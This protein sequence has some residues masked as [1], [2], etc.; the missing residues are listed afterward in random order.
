MVVK[1]SIG[2]YLTG[3][4][5]YVP[6]AYMAY[7]RRDFRR[8]SGRG[9]RAEFCYNVFLRHL[10]HVRAQ[11]CERLISVI[12]EIGPGTS[13]G[14]G[15]AGLIFG[16]E[17]YVAFDKVP[18]AEL[19][20]SVDLFD[21]LAALFRARTPLAPDE[22]YPEVRIPVPSLEFPQELC[23]GA[24]LAA[25]LSD[26]RLMDIRRSLLAD[27]GCFV[28][29]VAPWTEMQAADIP[30]LDLLIAHDV[31]EHVDDLEE[32][33]RRLS[34]FMA[35]GGVLSNHIDFKCHNLFSVWDGHWIADDW[36]WKLIRGRK[37]VL[38]NRLPYSAHARLSASAGFREIAASFVTGKPSD[39][40]GV[41]A[42]PRADLFVESDRFIQRA[43]VIAVR[44]TSGG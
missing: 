24:D 19:G 29:Y 32:T 20:K 42:L 10:A 28:S 38:L 12:G 6:P 33:Y 41:S 7:K 40:R 25:C 39:L 8:R 36:Q 21:E 27:D 31:M 13:I 11:G 23:L 43:H 26:N 9:S 3:M 35:P 16:A 17:R 34:E 4:L 2:P 37:P 1:G 22:T 14:L 15:L 44:P 5:S 18:F 30:Q